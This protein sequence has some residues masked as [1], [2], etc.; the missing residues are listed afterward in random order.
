MGVIGYLSVEFWWRI[1]DL[2]L[3]R[4]DSQGKF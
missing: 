4:I 1:R 3:M 2:D